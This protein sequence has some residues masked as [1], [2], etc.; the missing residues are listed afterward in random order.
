MGAAGLSSTIERIDFEAW[1]GQIWEAEISSIG[2]IG[3][4]F[5]DSY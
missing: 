1:G 5:V 3:D 4:V 2:Q